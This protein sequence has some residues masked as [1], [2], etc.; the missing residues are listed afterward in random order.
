MKVLR[1]ELVPSATKRLISASACPSSL[2]FRIY[3][4]FH[5]S[6]RRSAHHLAERALTA[7]TVNLTVAFAIRD[8]LEILTSRAE[9]KRG[10]ATPPSAELMRNAVMDLTESI[11]SVRLA[12]KAILTSDAKVNL[13]FHPF[14]S[15]VL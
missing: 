2:A 6:S 5:P 4:A 15:L 8:T 14:Q 3:S 7:S 11:A 12:S 1:A 10:L 13:Y 9:L